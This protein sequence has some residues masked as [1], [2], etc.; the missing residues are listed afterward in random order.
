M[1]SY[2][3]ALYVKKAMKL[4]HSVRS[5]HEA[6]LERKK[7]TDSSLRIVLE[8]SLR[9]SANSLH[10]QKL[11][12]LGYISAI[13]SLFLRFLAIGLKNTYMLLCIV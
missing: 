1:A 2:A 12:S 9:I 13:C 6:P 4:T 8:K 11:E 5:K 7:R 10:C 3:D